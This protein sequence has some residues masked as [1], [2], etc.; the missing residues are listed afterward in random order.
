MGWFN[1]FSL[2]GLD[3]HVYQTVDWCVYRVSKFSYMMLKLRFNIIS[4]NIIKVKLRL[5]DLWKEKLWDCHQIIHRV[6]SVYALGSSRLPSRDR[7]CWKARIKVIKVWLKFWFFTAILIWDSHKP[8]GPQGTVYGKTLINGDED[9]SNQLGIRIWCNAK[10][11][12]EPLIYS[13]NQIQE[14]F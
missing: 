14:M 13:N 6:R 7:H 8:Y 4:H 3:N 11:I 2:R 5:K 1:T 10:I 9:T 12:S